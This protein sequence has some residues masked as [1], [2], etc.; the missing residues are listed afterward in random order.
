MKTDHE[1]FNADPNDER[2]A[3]EETGKPSPS[4]LRQDSVCSEEGAHAEHG[5]KNETGY[6]VVSE[7]RSLKLL[8]GQPDSCA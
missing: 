1:D 8:D 7:R 4:T 3:D 6:E 5:D 2:D